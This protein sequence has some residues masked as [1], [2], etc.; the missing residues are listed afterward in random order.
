VSDSHAVLGGVGSETR[1]FSQTLHDLYHIAVITDSVSQGVT[2][3]QQVED[4][5]LVGGYYGCQE[6]A[7]KQR[8]TLSTG[9][10]SV[11]SFLD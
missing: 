5:K 2:S 8:Y 3:L 7:L 10:L 6:G 1:G 11:T 9:V 4:V